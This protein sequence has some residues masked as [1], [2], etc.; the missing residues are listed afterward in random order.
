MVDHHGNHPL[1]CRVLNQYLSQNF[2][3]LDQFTFHAH[4]EGLHK[5]RCSY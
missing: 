2:L 5:S 1:T 3:K 4:K